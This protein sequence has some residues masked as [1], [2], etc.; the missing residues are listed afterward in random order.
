MRRLLTRK[1][2]CWMGTR[3]KFGRPYK[4]CYNYLTSTQGVF[5]MLFLFERSCIG[6]SEREALCLFPPTFWAFL[7]T[8][9]NGESTSLTGT[10]PSANCST[11]FPWRCLLLSP[12]NF[13]SRNS[14]PRYSL[15]YALFSTVAGV[16]CG[17]ATL[18]ATNMTNSSYWGEKK[19]SAGKNVK[20]VLLMISKHIGP[21]DGVCLDLGPRSRS[22]T[23]YLVRSYGESCPSRR[24]CG[25]S[26]PPGQ[27]VCVTFK[28]VMTSLKELQHRRQLTT[29]TQTVLLI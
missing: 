4:P 7:Y 5:Q 3:R 9:M 6:P 24:R 26:D 12:S 21:K 2:L 22:Q 23:S 11:A 17:C 19:L 13:S 28:T 10:I 14:Q 18:N 1:I 16:R 8:R 15:Y 29:R 20:L 25:I 27:T